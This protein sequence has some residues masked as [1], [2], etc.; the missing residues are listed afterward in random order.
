MATCR[1]GTPLRG[2]GPS[3]VY[4]LPVAGIALLALAQCAPAPRSGEREPLISVG[5]VTGAQSSSFRLTKPATL[6]L[7]G[8]AAG[9]LS[10]GTY[11]IR[12]EKPLH[13]GTASREEISSGRNASTASGLRLVLLDERGRKAGEAQ[14][15]ISLRNGDLV[16]LGRSGRRRQ[17]RV[18]P[19]RVDFLL[20]RGQMAIV[21]RLPLEEYVRGVLL[22]EISPK[23]PQEA[24]RAQAIAVRSMALSQRRQAHAGAPFE[25]CADW[26]CQVYAGVP[27]DKS[28]VD[29]A[30]KTTRG[31]VLYSGG[32]V[33]QALYSANCGGHT[34]SAA[35]AWRGSRLDYLRGVLDG[36]QDVDP[37]L[38]KERIL[39]QWVLGKP[40]VF[41]KDSPRGHFRWTR[42]IKASVLKT[43]LERMLG[44]TVGDVLELAV[45]RRGVSGRAFRIQITT[46]E[47]NFQVDGELRIRHLLAQPAL[48]SSCFAVEV[49]EGG[50]GR[51]F[52]LHGAGFGHGVGLCQDGA[53]AM[54]KRGYRYWEILAHYYPGTR[55]LQI[56]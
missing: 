41:C 13:R 38:T 50:A 12:L 55:L 19:G 20:W 53:A 16:F 43:R 21:N 22:A 48:P 9:S 23:S 39:E 36:P 24:L 51:E 18:Y 52:V 45:L 54:A 32:T 49:R 31:M 11:R 3:R 29:E 1:V 34:E 47:G 26:H 2:G 37:D 14:Q 15:A 56:Y 4:F 17:D 30:V 40:D 33:I 28:P 27:L 10:E 8:E 46:T 35:R 5:L 42:V 25:L 6:L 44:R 7:D